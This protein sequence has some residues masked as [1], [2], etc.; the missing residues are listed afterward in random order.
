MSTCT[1]Y[2]QGLKPLSVSL[3]CSF[4]T[5][6][7]TWWLKVLL[8]CVLFLATFLCLYEKGE[9]N[10]KCKRKESKKLLQDE[11][12]AFILFSLRYIKRK[13]VMENLGNGSFFNVTVELNDS[14]DTEQLCKQHVNIHT[15]VWPSRWRD[16]FIS[17]RVCICKKW[18]QKLFAH[19]ITLQIM[20]CILKIVSSFY[21]FK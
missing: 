3:P 1:H 11:L 17:V 13:K 21:I 10:L 5:F 19:L 9:C 15:Q 12:Q 14:C 18:P 2:C 7:I 6:S 20:N 8:S 16:A 4:Y